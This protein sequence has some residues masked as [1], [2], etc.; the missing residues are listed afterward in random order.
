M[1]DFK[2]LTTAVTVALLGLPASFFKP[3][4]TGREHSTHLVSSVSVGNPAWV[5]GD[6]YHMRHK[7]GKLKENIF[8]KQKP[9]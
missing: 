9:D 6:E 8:S 3:F 7:C 2:L 1:Q 5:A 4:A